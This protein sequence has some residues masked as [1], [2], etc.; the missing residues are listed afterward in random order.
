MRVA[1]C[2][3]G[4]PRD[5]DYT[6]PFFQNSLLN[7]YNIDVFGAFWIDPL[8]SDTINENTNL[9][10]KHFSESDFIDL[11]KPK[12]CKFIEFNN[13]VIDKINE[14]NYMKLGLAGIEPFKNYHS[15]CMF[16]MIE[17]VDRLRREYEKISGKYDV[18][19]RCRP[20]LVMYDKLNLNDLQQKIIYMSKYI[21]LPGFNDTC[22]WST[23]ETANMFSDLFSFFSSFE[24][25]QVKVKTLEP[26]HVIQIY[27]QINK[28]NIEWTDNIHEISRWVKNK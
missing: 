23:S 18:V 28:L 20:D 6:W 8:G 26:E 15:L 5:I 4:M 17:Q 3:S 19:I 2:L 7:H 11:C 9:N 22:W 24:F 16:Y 21:T 25:S 1:L 27:M 12:M 10:H 14:V 13:T